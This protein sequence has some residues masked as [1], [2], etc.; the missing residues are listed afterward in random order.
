[1]KKVAV[2]V[3]V[4]VAWMWVAMAG[5]AAYKPLSVAVPETSVMVLPP[6]QPDLTNAWAASTAYSRDTIFY[7]SNRCYWVTVAGTTWTNGPTHTDGDATNGTATCRYIHARRNGFIISNVGTTAVYA[8]Y[9]DTAVTNRG[10]VLLPNGA[11]VLGSGEPVYQGPIFAISHGANT[12][13]LTVH[14]E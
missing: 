2:V 4:A 12:N 9:A 6:A 3:A 5:P 13:T 8:T 11:G 1:M 7:V 10:L 14:E